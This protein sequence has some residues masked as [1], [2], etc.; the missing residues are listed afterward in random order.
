MYEF[1][2]NW[3]SDINI[4]LQ[5]VNELIPVVFIFLYRYGWNST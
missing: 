5:G 2:E 4:L 3:T 1:R